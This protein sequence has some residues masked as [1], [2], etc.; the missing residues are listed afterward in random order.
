MVERRLG[1][2]R[3]S[4]Y[5]PEDGRYISQD[6]IGLLSG[7]FGFYNYVEDSNAWLDIFGLVDRANKIGLI[8]DAQS[9]R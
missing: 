8:T 3:Y 9:K 1:Y 4:Y 6:P 5:D 7:E 2:N